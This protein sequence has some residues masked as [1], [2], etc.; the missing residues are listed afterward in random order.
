MIQACSV[1]DSVLVRNHLKLI[2]YGLKGMYLILSVTGLK[3][4]HFN[5]TAPVAYPCSD[6]Y[7]NI[8]VTKFSFFGKNTSKAVVPAVKKQPH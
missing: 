5:S 3:G 7:E 4:I 8:V 1:S 6:T 2:G